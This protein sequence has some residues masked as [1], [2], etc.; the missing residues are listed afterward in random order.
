MNESLRRQSEHLEQLVV[1]T[2]RRLRRNAVLTG[3][4]LSI[5]ATAGW[6]AAAALLDLLLVLPVPLRLAAWGVFWAL[7]LV[8]TVA[9]VLWPTFRPMRLEQI[10]FHIEDVIGR[11]H[12]RLV[13]V[14]DLRRTDRMDVRSEPFAG[15]LIEQTTQRLAGYDIDAVADPKPVRH[16]ALATGVTVALAAALLLVM[17]LR[18]STAVMRV[19]LPRRPIPPVSSVKLAAHPGDVEVLQGDPLRVWATVRGGDVDQ[20]IL[21]MKSDDGRHLNYSLQRAGEG[22]FA[23]TLSAVDTSYDYHIAGGGTWTVPSRITMVR[24]PVVDTLA[25]EVQL[26]DYMKLPQRRPVGERLT[27][28]SA[29][30]GATIHL[31]ATVT[32][33]PAEGCINLFE[34]DTLATQETQSRETVWFDDDLPADAEISGTW[35]WTS[36]STYSGTRAHTFS[37]ARQPYGFRTRLVQLAVGAGDTF[38]LYARPDGK[39][40]PARLTV[41]APVGDKTHELLWDSP[42]SPLSDKEKEGKHYIGH[43]PSPGAW[44]RLEVPGSIFQ[45]DGNNPPVQVAG[46]SFEIGGGAILFD[47]AGT[48][49]HV[50]REVKKTDLKRVATFPM[51]RDGQTGRWLG[52][53]GAADGHVTV[54]FRNHLGHPSAA[55]QPIPVIATADQAPT[56]IVER[57]GRDL[58]LSEP[59]TVPLVIRAFDDYGVAD[60]SIRIG[61]RADDLTDARTIAE[62]DEPKT[63]RLAVGALDAQATD[64]APGQ[65]ITYRVFARDLAGQETAG[66]P[67]RIELAK[68]QGDAAQEALRDRHSLSGILENIDQLVDL[69]DQLAL[70]ALKLAEAL[71]EGLEIEVSDA[72]VI[73]LLNPDGTPMTADQIKDLLTGW[74]GNLSDQERKELAEIREQI[75][76]ERGQLL[77][78]SQSL[79]DAAGAEQAMLILPADAE[80]LRAMAARAREMGEMMPLLDDQEVLDKEL[81][82][83]LDGLQGLSDEGAEEMLGLRQQLQQIMVARQSLATSP[84]ES[85][86]QLDAMLAQFQAQ[87]A[88]RQIRTLDGYLQ[89]QQELLQDMRRRVAV[90]RQ[91][92]EDAAPPQLDEL[93]EKQ[94]EELDPEALELIQRARELLAKRLTKMRENQDVLPPAP[95]IPPGRREQAMPVE[96]DTPEEDPPDKQGRQNLE[97][98]KRQLDDLAREEELDWWDMPVDVPP[99]PFTLDPSRRFQGRD[100]RP[101]APPD[102]RRV[103]GSATPRQ[104]LMEHQDELHQSLTANSNE[105]AGVQDELSRTM[106]QL[107]QAMSQVQGASTILGSP[108]MRQAMGMA[109][110]AAAGAFANTLPRQG[111]VFVID[112]GA[113]QAVPVPDAALYRLPPW[114]RQPLLQGMQERGPEAYQPLIDAYYRQLSEEVEK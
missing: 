98:I 20:L 81:I 35:R 91:E 72:G 77:S 21:H 112:A 48:L 69:D 41:R 105:I 52:S 40:P 47:R 26:P 57:P 39:A 12:N 46:L 101:V 38:F 23:F 96:Q 10:A 66:E 45:P 30:A 82:A 80:A 51:E 113:Y 70:G 27:E 18:M 87:R 65:S 106:S 76:K 71:P 11:M 83:W 9:M 14:I 68:P 25:A 74:E 108:G 53:F 90:A 2:R 100:M 73:T 64:L 107:Q 16:V 49:R 92:T 8:S 3:L 97:G 114:L 61:A 102:P 60:V 103:S 56:I 84:A 44:H 85:Q 111:V 29:P 78:L 4:G 94:Q 67:F 79:F 54:E 86:R 88:L 19:L 28:I 43:L 63:S 1:L 75:R 50:T 93:S 62:Y 15:R 32:G 109:G 59:Q 24:R 36:E 89:S 22:V 37:W 42:L 58:T 95:W 13:T 104:L 110:W 7:L 34:T 99:T 6:L 33:D 5:V 17:P 55:M 31:A